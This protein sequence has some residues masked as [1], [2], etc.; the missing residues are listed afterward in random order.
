M[1]AMIASVGVGLRHGKIS[2]RLAQDLVGLTKFADLG[3]K[4]PDPLTFLC[5]RAGPGATVALGLTHPAP[6]RLRVQPILPAIELIASHC[7][8]YLP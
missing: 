2:R 8:P 4:S 3:L 5:R 1:K 6:Q 7:E